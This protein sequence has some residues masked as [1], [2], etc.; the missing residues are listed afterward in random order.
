MSRHHADVFSSVDGKPEARSLNPLD[1]LWSGI[2]RRSAYE[3]LSLLGPRQGINRKLAQLLCA[4]R[5][6]ERAKSSDAGQGNLSGT[7]HAYQAPSAIAGTPIDLPKTLK[8]TVGWLIRKARQAHLVC[9]ASRPAFLTLGL[10]HPGRDT[11]KDVLD[12]RNQGICW[13]FAHN[14]WI[15]WR[16]V[17]LSLGLRLPPCDP[18]TWRPSTPARPAVSGP[19]P[20]ARCSGSAM[21]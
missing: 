14:V 11:P 5:Y 10:R 8:S 9:A 3:D 15:V 17:I 2:Y 19:H 1:P 18:R 7:T 16:L 13:Q 20:S 12:K 6:T 4:M 21:I